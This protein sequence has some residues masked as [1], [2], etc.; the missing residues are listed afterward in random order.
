MMEMD[1]FMGLN[2]ICI[3]ANSVWCDS[4]QQKVSENHVI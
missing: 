1:H 4:D 2:V 3:V